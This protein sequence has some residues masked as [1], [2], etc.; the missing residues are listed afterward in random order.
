MDF[1]LMCL[2]LCGHLLTISAAPFRS[3]T[4]DISEII[5]FNNTFLAKRFLF[6]LLKFEHEDV[7]Y[8]P[9]T[10]TGRK[11]LKFSIKETTCLT[12]DTDDL[13]NCEFKPDGV[14]MVCEADIITHQQE[15]KITG[16]CMTKTNTQK[17]DHIMRRDVVDKTRERFEFSVDP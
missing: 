5:N 14:E 1:S 8:V 9:E 7:P 17:G 16:Y 3:S 10:S 11:V 6:K 2:L 13:E 15:R 4:E 12:S